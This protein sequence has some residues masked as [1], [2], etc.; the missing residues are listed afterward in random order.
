MNFPSYGTNNIYAIAATQENDTGSVGMTNMSDNNN[1]SMSMT[2]TAAAKNN[3]DTKIEKLLNSDE[4]VDI[5]TLAYVWGYPLVTNLR[6]IDYSTDPS[7]FSESE[8]YGPWNTLNH[9]TQLVNASFSQFVTP[10]VDT[11][12]SNAYYDVNKEPLVIS[13]PDNITR[14]FT[15]QFMDAW[16]NNYDY[17][18]TRTN[19]TNGG[20]YLLTGPNWNGTI[21]DDMTEIESP[22]PLGMIFERVIVN[23]P[24]DLQNARAIQQSITV[25]PLSMYENDEKSSSQSLSST[26][27]SSNNNNNNNNNNSDPITFYPISISGLPSFIPSTGIKFFNELAYYMGN[28]MPPSNQFPILEKLAKIGIVPNKNLNNQSATNFNETI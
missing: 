2:S 27:S 15:L 3:T 24:E 13:V 18:G 1:N 10:N 6:T 4:S 9:R 21:P 23:G 20:T 22:T 5:A 8:A 11:L 17:L 25:V 26:T 7:H 14:Y 28:N 12:Y 19:G 16:T